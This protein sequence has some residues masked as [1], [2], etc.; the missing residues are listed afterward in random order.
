M[1]RTQIPIRPIQVDYECDECSKGV[2]RQKG[3]TMFMSDP[4]KIPHACTECGNEVIFTERY[5]MVRYAL[6]GE[7]LDLD[8]YKQ[9]T[10]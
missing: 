7:A 8:N 6:E 4:P 9:Q 10:L 3:N 1:P 5:P 2:M